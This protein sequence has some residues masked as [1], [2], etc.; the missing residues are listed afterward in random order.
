MAA[1][2]KAFVGEGPFAWSVGVA[3]IACDRWLLAFVTW[4][5]L[6]P[7]R[8]AFAFFFPETPKQY[9]FENLNAW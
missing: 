6:A 8:R 9:L 1:L 7:W 3:Y 5:A 4:Q 2:T